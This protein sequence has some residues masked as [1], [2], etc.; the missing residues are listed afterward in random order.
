MA[1]HD[2]F[3]ALAERFRGP[4]AAYVRGLLWDPV[5]LPDALQATLLVAF[6]KFAEFERGTNFGAWI[7]R[8][9]T[10][11][12]FNLNRKARRPEPPA[13]ELAESLD[14]EA[15]YEE[16]L[17]DP[18]PILQRVDGDLRR[19]FVELND[20]E[21]ASLLLVTVCGVTCREAASVLSMPIGTVMG[22]LARARGKMRQRLAAVA[23]SRGWVREAP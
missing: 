9:A 14:L 6:E 12:V 2:E 15:A 5:E 11:V 8:I 20:A 18:E 23:R 19:A 22:N 1:S 13:V 7:F 4:L 10:N 21:R 3:A 16:V 17:K